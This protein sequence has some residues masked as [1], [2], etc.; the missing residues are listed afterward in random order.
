MIMPA[1]ERRQTD[2]LAAGAPLARS[3]VEDAGTA[4]AAALSSDPEGY[5]VARFGVDAGADNHSVLLLLQCAR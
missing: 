3:A 2:G 5:T 1:L 4:G